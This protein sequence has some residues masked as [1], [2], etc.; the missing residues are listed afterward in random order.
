MKQGEKSGEAAE[1]ERV[2][3]LGHL[4]V[5]GDFALYAECGTGDEILPQGVREKPGPSHP[6]PACRLELGALRAFAAC[7]QLVSE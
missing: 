5:R 3:F 7:L 6:L 4:G 1:S 2:G